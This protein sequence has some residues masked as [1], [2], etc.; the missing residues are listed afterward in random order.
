MIRLPPVTFNIVF[1][2]REPA[3]TADLPVHTGDRQ[4]FPSLQKPT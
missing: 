1:D 4:L 2:T 3:Q